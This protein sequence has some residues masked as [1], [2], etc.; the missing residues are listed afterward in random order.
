MEGSTFNKD[1]LPI[2]FN[3]LA[4][5]SYT[6]LFA[7]MKTVKLL[8]FLAIYP[9]FSEKSQGRNWNFSMKPVY[10]LLVMFEGTMPMLGLYIKYILV[11]K[12]IILVLCQ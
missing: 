12:S 9:E 1:P 10:L 8:L 6:V 11:L 2:S 4:R 5:F 7:L 3:L